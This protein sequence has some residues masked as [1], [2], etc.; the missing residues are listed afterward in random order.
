[1]AQEVV[2]A[3]AQEGLQAEVRPAAGVA[4]LD[5]GRVL[6]LQH[7]HDGRWG[8]PGGGVERG[9]SPE[10]AARREL[11]EETG[12]DAGSLTLVGAFGGPAFEV[13]YPSGE[14]TA[15]V[16]VL[17][18]AT[19]HSGKVTLQTAEVSDARWCDEAELADIDLQ[20][21]MR[22]MLPQAFRWLRERR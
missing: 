21:D 9:E 17:Y 10:D 1:M 3:M 15:Y 8:T 13:T 19:R 5:A 22:L 20:P 14:T 7:V 2:T 4:V 6:L 11:F 18:A 12:L 16:V